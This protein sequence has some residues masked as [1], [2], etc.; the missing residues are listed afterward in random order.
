MHR[1]TSQDT[2][3]EPGKV[4]RAIV[5]SFYDHG[6]IVEFFCYVLV[7]GERKDNGGLVP[8]IITCMV[9]NGSQRNFLYQFVSSP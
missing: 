7:S 1:R 9:F 4:H 8:H 3:P 2:L 6:T 5:T